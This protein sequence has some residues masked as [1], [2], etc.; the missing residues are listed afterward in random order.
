MS[1]FLLDP[2]VFLSNTHLIVGLEGS[3][4]VGIFVTKIRLN[5]F[6]IQNNMERSRFLTLWP[7]KGWKRLIRQ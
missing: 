3:F 2:R 5:E 1:L 6:Y 7:W 4:G